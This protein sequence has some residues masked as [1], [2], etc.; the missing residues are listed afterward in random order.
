MRSSP[1]SPRLLIGAA[2]AVVLSVLVWSLWWRL[3][4][5]QAGRLLFAIHDLTKACTD[6]E[7]SFR[8]PE[9]QLPGGAAVLIGAA[10]AHLQFTQQQLASH[11][12]LISNQVSI[13]MALSS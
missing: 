12:P 5:H 9:E 3:S 13:Q 1:R 2:A 10:I 7:D 4:E 8:K 6:V 11:D